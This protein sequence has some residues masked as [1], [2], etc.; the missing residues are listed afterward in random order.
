MHFCI[1]GLEM[2]VSFEHEMILRALSSEYMYVLKDMQN[3][4]EL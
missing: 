4:V 3:S 2:N 1:I